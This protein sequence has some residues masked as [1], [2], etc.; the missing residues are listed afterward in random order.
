MKRI[1]VVCTANVCRSVMVAGL[2]RARLAANALSEQVEVTSAGIY[3]LLGEPADPIV[4]ELLAEKGIDLG[5]HESSGLTQEELDRADWVLVMEEMHRQ[6]IF[7]RA[8]QHLHKVWLLT[9]VNRGSGD[10]GDPYGE[11]RKAYEQ[12]LTQVDDIL[13]PGWK[14]LLHYLGVE[15]SS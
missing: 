11:G 13:D 3:P 12:T 1:L 10:I 2:L 8:P 9:E 14:N 5:S 6:A 7:Y 4:R 15:T